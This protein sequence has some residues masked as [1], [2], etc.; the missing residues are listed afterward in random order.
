MRTSATHPLQIAEVQFAEGQGKIGITF[1]PGKK[2]QGAFTGNWD[3]DL[4]I[5]LEAI[6][7]WNAAAVVTL[8]E[9]HEF[10]SLGVAGLG[11]AIQDRHIQWY[12]LPIRDVSTP[13]RGFEE[14]WLAAG[15]ELRA[16][17]RDGFNVLVHCKGGLGRAG[18]TA[19]RLLIEL[20][21]GADHAI[22]LVRQAR[23]GAIETASQLEFVRDL[24][25]IPERQ[26][27]QSRNVIED[28]ALGAMLGLAV[29]DA[30]GTTLEFK[31]RDQAPRLVD[32]VGGGPFRLKPGQWTDDTSMALALMDS[33]LAYPDLDEADLMN[34]FVD[35][36]ENGAYSCTGQC[37]DI[38]ITT[39]NALAR[40][41]ETGDPFAGST[42]PRTAGNG[43]LMRLAPVAVRY[44]NDLAMLRD[45][46]ARQSRTTHGAPQAVDACVGFAEVLANAIAGRPRSKVVQLSAEP[47]SRTISTIIGGS[48]RGMPRDQVASS[49]YVA[50]SLEAAL[51]CVGR[52]G[53]FAQ[54]VLLAANLG[55]DADTTAAITGQLA[56][57]LYGATAIP[58]EW[59]AL[60]AE[61]V[62]IEAA[63]KQ[64]FAVS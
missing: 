3:R 18:M 35:W 54:A 30:V 48:W 1:C 51:W 62:E 29:G 13:D 53:N 52:T 44:W 33:L 39:R 49:G 45:V 55:D 10:V 38:G 15:E 63:T 16:I 27:A 17:L 56:G 4:D 12:P 26:P 8:L 43:S 58:A 2:Q 37:F 14:A 64:L 32:M 50:H 25:G 9:D 57:A 22:N 7:T 5:D 61:D 36:H 11:Q 21:M 24:A 6:R 42:N 20:G 31:A 41:K 47:C 34:R 46:A 23:P 40:W 60:L 28:R 59:K 19:A